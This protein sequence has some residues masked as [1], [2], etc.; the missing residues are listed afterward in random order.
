[1]PAA[2]YAGPNAAILLGGDLSSGLTVVSATTP[3]N[4]VYIG[5]ASKIEAVALVSAISATATC[6]INLYGILPPARMNGDEGTKTSA[7]LASASLTNN[8]ETRLSATLTGFQFV[9]VEI[10]PGASTNLTLGKIMFFS[11]GLG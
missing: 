11:G 7:P 5:G 9:D 4:R 3:F 8:I 10:A 6:K 2:T 1:M